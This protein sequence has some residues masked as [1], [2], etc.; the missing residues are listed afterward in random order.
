M[1]PRTAAMTDPTSNAMASAPK[2]S[3]AVSM[4]NSVSLNREIRRRGKRF[5]WIANDSIINF[6]YFEILD[7]GSF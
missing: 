6:N 2:A 3:A 5:R 1:E 7:H 4:A